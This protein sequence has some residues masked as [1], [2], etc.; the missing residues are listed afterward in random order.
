MKKLFA[1]LFALSVLSLFLQSCSE[2]PE[3]NGVEWGLK[4]QIGSFVIDSVFSNTSGSDSRFGTHGDSDE[5]YYRVDMNGIESKVPD[6]STAPH[7]GKIYGWD[8][9]CF[10]SVYFMPRPTQD[11]IPKDYSFNVDSFGNFN[12]TAI[13]KDY[14]GME[15]VEYWIRLN[16]K[17]DASCYPENSPILVHFSL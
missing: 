2:D 4:L 9:D 1:G 15:S 17:S 14:S 12:F 6:Y 16:L 11:S 3:D 13:E 5:K 8:E 7:T 10:E